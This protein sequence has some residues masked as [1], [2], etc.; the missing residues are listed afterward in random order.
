MGELAATQE[1]LEEWATL[2]HLLH[3]ILAASAPFEASV[4]AVTERY[5]L[6][7]TDRRVLMRRWRPCQTRINALVDFCEGIE[8]IGRPYQ[9]DAHELRGARY[10]V[11]V[12]AAQLALE[13]TL[14]DQQPLV[15]ALAEL[16]DEF[17]T[18]CHR[19]LAVADREMQ[20]LVQH[21]QRLSATRGGGLA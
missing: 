5:E 7:L 4:A 11:D 17:Q 14:Q 19:H 13:D 6:D 10:A 21:L 18:V 12:V 3:E 15:E 8:H 9:R 16:A 1:R 2:H 20:K